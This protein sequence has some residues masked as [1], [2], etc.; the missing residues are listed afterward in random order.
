MNHHAASTAFREPPPL[1]M[2]ILAAGAALRRLC[3]SQAVVIGPGIHLYRLLDEVGW[4]DGPH[5][6]ALDYVGIDHGGI[7]IGFPHEFLNGSDVL[8]RL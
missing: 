7:E 4:A 6:P 2:R 8:P 3:P 1:A 5:R